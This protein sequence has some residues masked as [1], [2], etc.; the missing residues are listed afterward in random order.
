MRALYR[1]GEAIAQDLSAALVLLARGDHVSVPV[2]CLTMAS[3]GRLPAGL[4]QQPLAAHHFHNFSGMQANFPWQSQAL[5]FIAQMQ[6]W[7]QLPAGDYSQLVRQS[8]RS[9]CYRR[10]L[11]GIC[12]APVNDHKVE[13]A[14]LSV[15]QTPGEYGP[16]AVA[17]DAF[18]DAALFDSASILR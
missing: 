9:D 8:W 10:F 2:E 1:A 4:G 17:E 13:G 3:S 7:G 12:D 14:H 6:R 18:V 5:W 15:W 11:N 16:L